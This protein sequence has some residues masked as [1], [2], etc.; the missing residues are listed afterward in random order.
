MI[1]RLRGRVLEHDAAMVI[2]DCRGVGYGVFVAYDEQSRLP[3]GSDVDLYISEQIKED[4]HD[5]YGFLQA[6]RKDLFEKLI[7]VNGVGPKAGMALLNIGPEAQLRTAI[8]SGDVKYLTG[9]KGV[10]KKA[11]EKVVI[12]LKN[13]VGLE[14]SD[15]ATDFV[16][17]AAVT[18]EAVE[19]LVAL[20]HTPQGAAELL[21]GID[22]TLPANDRIKQALKV[23]K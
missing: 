17:Y 23:G 7:S 14:A 12:D 20:G 2:V 15:S 6:S 1:A 10:G 11:A 13:K 22:T 16:T 8:A 9:A 5:L 4:A 21:R 19:A 18:D 3:N